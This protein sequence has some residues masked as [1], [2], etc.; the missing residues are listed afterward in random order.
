MSVHTH[1]EVHTCRHTQ[2]VHISTCAHVHLHVCNCPVYSST[3]CAI[4]CVRPVPALCGADSSASRASPGKGRRKSEPRFPHHRR[5]GHPLPI[6]GPA[7]CPSPCGHVRSCRR[8]SLASPALP[9]PCWPR[10][11][12]V[13]AGGP[14]VASQTRCLPPTI[15][16]PLPTHRYPHPQ[17]HPP[18]GAAAHPYNP[19]AGNC[20][21]GPDCSQP[22]VWGDLV[23][24]C[25]WGQRCHP[26]NTNVTPGDVW[27]GADVVWCPARTPRTSAWWPQGAWA[28]AWQR[29]AG[30]VLG[31]D[32]PQ[33]PLSG[34]PAPTREGWDSEGDVLR[35]PRDGSWW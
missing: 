17:P 31:L 26:V 29:R 2:H 3:M 7:V 34:M 1:P 13:A 20:S 9:P 6:L 8:V 33:G 35:R 11:P 30:G 18:L 28:H 19:G 22:Q 5:V 10:V 14:C 15:S 4:P 23:M 12:G 27:G 21:W 32:P 16:Y 24:L 25:L